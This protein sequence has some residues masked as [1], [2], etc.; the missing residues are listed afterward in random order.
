MVM[1]MDDVSTSQAIQS[2][3]GKHKKIKEN[4]FDF[5]NQ[6][7]ETVSFCCFYLHRI[8]YFIHNSPLKLK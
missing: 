1:W 4:I 2:V 6:N 5:K 7:P 8:W 3:A